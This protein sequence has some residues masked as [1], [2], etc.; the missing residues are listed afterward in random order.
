MI[1][2]NKS[3]EHVEHADEGVHADHRDSS[4]GNTHRDTHDD[5]VGAGYAAESRQ[6]EQFGGVNWGAGFFGWLVAVAVAVLLTSIFG[7]IAAAVGSST[8]VTQSAAER[9]AG[10]IGI[11]AAIVLLVV[12]MLAYYTGGYVAGRMSRFNGGKQGLAVWVFGLLVTIIAVVIGVA[13]GSQYNILDRVNLP[14]MPIPTDALSLGGVIV[15]AAVLLGTLLAAMAGGK[16][17]RRYHRK[18]DSAGMF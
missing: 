1:R 5:T 6:R 15:A 7:A 3:S 17:G 4:H 2:R 9:E 14:T 13:F 8:D 18:V 10:T 16:V 11:V 12:L